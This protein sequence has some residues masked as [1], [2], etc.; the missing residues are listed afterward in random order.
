MAAPKHLPPQYTDLPD[1]LIAL[2]QKGS[3]ANDG[4][5]TEYPATR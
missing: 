3:Y 5:Y 1:D 2:F 4:K